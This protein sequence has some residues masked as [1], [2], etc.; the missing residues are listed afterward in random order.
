MET[1]KFENPL[2]DYSTNTP[3]KFDEKYFNKIPPNTPGVYIVGVKIPVNGQGEKFCPLYVG[4][5]L[6]IK[7]R[8]N[9][10][11]LNEKE[12][13]TSG[14]LN[15][16]QELFD[17]R[18][19]PHLFYNDIEIMEK[20]I[21]RGP[22]T[23]K[24]QEFMKPFVFKII[25]NKKYGGN[26]TLIWFPDSRFFDNYLE[27]TEGTSKYPN[28]EANHS[29]SIKKDGGDLTNIKVKSS[30]KLKKRIID[31][32]DTIEKKFYFVYSQIKKE[33]YETSAAEIEF[34]IK[35]ELKLKGIHTYG[36][37]KGKTS[38]NICFDDILELVNM[39]K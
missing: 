36:D 31:V 38:I 1:I 7:K 15:S 28:S 12:V 29:A 14:Y 27:L 6:N 30:K 35:N 17:I 19:K 22:H 37:A 39:K 4:I 11:Y 21:L 25:K 20:F 5:S 3:W 16:C 10:H 24:E 34:N 2:G 13:R 8:L 9:E 33:S 26:N 32:K 18:E 23:K